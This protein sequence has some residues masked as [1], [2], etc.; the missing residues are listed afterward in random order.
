MEQITPNNIYLGDCYELIKQIPNNSIDLIIT[1][2]PYEI[3]SCGNGGLFKYEGR[4][5]S[6]A[7]MNEIIENNFANGFDYSLLNEWVRV[8]KNIYIYIYMVQQRTNT[9]LYRLFR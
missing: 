6:Q 1:D 2:P 7:Y 4:S 8:M 3:G 5:H 9:C